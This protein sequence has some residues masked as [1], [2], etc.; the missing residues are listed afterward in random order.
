MDK[1]YFMK[2]ALKEA[3]KAYDLEEVPI[4]AVIVKDDKIIARAHNLKETKRDTT[5]HAELLAIQKASKKIGAWRLSECEIY[6]TLEPCPMCAGAIVNARI[7]KVYIGTKDPKAGA[8]GSVLNLFEDYK[9]N[10][11]VE[12]EYDILNSECSNILK[13]FFK[14]LRESKK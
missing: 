1:E 14:M 13:D 12:V 10:H 4:G 2:Q 3:R 7:K 8:A 9:L 11:K 6:T 5:N